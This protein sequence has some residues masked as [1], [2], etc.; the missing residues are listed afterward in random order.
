MWLGVLAA[1]VSGYHVY[2]RCPWRPERESDPL[3]LE[4]AALWF[5]E[6]APRSSGEEAS[7]LNQ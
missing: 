3:K 7:V 5:L 1:C 2:T 4:W 6:L